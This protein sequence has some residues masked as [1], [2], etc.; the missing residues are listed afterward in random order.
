[1]KRSGR[2]EPMWVVIHKCI[3]ATQE[4]SLY[5]YLHLKPAK[6]I[7]FSFYVVCF[8]LNKRARQVLPWGWGRRHGMKTMYTHVSKFKNNKIK[9]LKTNNNRDNPKP[10]EEHKYPISGRSKITSQIQVN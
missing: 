8:F 9:K 6:M 10:N 5:N 4:I 3:E 2:D 1:V 7:C